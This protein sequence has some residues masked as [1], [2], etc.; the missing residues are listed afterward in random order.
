MTAGL[1]VSR[2]INVDV[3]L[4]PAAAQ[5]PSV[6]TAL[7]I[8]DS[9]VINV[10]E[11]Y[12]SYASIDEVA[13]DFGD[14]APEYFAAELWFGQ[15]PS[16]EQ[17]YIGRW[18]KT[19]TE[20]LLLC[21]LLNATQQQIGNWTGIN[22]GSFH[23]AIDGG[24]PVSITALNFGAAG[25]MNAV[26]AIINAA[27]TGHG[28]DCI[29]NGQQFVFN[30][31]TTGAASAIAYLTAGAGGT[32]ISAQVAGTAA[33][34]AKEV[35]GIVAE[36]ALACV[37]IMDDQP[38]GFYMLMFAVVPADLSQN[39]IL[40]IAAYIEADAN[41]HVFTNNVN[42]ANA[43]S[44]SS[45]EDIGYQ[46]KQL[47]YNRSCYQYSGF[48]N[49]AMGSGDAI[50]ATTDFEGQN[51]TKTMAYKQEP[52]VQPELLLSSQANALDAKNYIYYATFNNGI[53]IIVNG[54]MASGLY[55]DDI[56]GADWMVGQVQTDLFNALFTTPTKIPQDDAGV[57]VLTTTVE[58]SLS[59]GLANGQIGPGVWE[60]D[61]FGTLKKGDYLEKGYYVFAPS[62]ASQS[63]G[64][65][66]A[67]E[68]P[69]IQAAVIFAGAIQKV[70]IVINVQR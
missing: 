4:E 32:D 23:I 52:G 58:A 9:N 12:R 29:W 68:S 28:A 39:D 42:D 41:P 66:A 59:V 61:G 22:N 5:Q 48:N 38:F 45:T 54:I 44:G 17:L 69:L 13:A 8:G 26:A 47:E 14:S 60:F 57:H 70:S 6:T 67:R 3:N 1:Q 27:T 64:A 7:F 46:L 53:P 55:F 63:A 2:L 34:G 16:P 31:L 62:V 65:R 10:S 24:G 56:Q 36:S 19:A 49:Y 33:T 50:M 35:N 30:S 43:L 51:T 37:Q 11:R 20:G 15:S 21:G 25:N 40:A 18:A